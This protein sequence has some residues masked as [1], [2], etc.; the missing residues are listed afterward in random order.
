MGLN[1]CIFTVTSPKSQR[2]NQTNPL[3]A[4]NTLWRPSMGLVRSAQE[5]ER[6]KRAQKVI[7]NVSLT[8]Y[9]KPLHSEEMKTHS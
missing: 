3:V 1:N 2:R 8:T 7:V 4:K 5:R 6:E 9:R